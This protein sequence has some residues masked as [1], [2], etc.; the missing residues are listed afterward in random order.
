MKILEGMYGKVENMIYLLKQTKIFNSPY[1]LRFQ[2]NI[3]IDSFS[4]YILI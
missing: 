1:K 2:K 3:A 4:C